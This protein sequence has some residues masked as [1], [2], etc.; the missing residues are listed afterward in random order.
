MTTEVKN[1]GTDFIEVPVYDYDGKEVMKE[2]VYFDY[3]QRGNDMLVSLHL[4]VS[5]I[6][7][8]NMILKENFRGFNIELI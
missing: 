6:D 3:K 2:K 8:I 7:D 4:Y 5:H 1:E